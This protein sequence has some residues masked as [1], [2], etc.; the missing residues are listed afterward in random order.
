[1]ESV[2]SNSTPRPGRRHHP[3]GELLGPPQPTVDRIVRAVSHHLLLLHRS[4]STFFVLGATGNVYTVSLSS[5]PACTCPD[6]ATPCK[7]I[8]FVFIRVLGVS[9][10]DSCLQRRTLRP[11]QL[12][13]LLATP[14]S[15]DAM[16]GPSLRERFH[17]DFFRARARPDGAGLPEEVHVEDGASC[18]I[19]LDEL[20]ERGGQRVVACGTCRNPVHEECLLRWKR[21]RGRRPAICVICRGRWRRAEQENAYV[22][23]GAYVSQDDQGESHQSICGAL[24]LQ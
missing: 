14:S 5:S 13:R 9:L 7:H 16:A 15:P 22:N 19:C 10:D 1:M 23:L 12:Q 21:S 2:A 8:L 18:P 3:P 17:R 6:R 11:C 24:S 4:E 20:K